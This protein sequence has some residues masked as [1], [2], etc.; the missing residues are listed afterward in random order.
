VKKVTSL[1][2]WWKRLIKPYKQ[3]IRAFLGWLSGLLLQIVPQGGYDEAITWTWKKWAFTLVVA[4][5]P[6]LMGFMKGGDTN[7]TDEELY[8]KVHKVKQ[9]RAAVGQEVTDPIGLPIAPKPPT[10]PAP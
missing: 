2:Q 8:D 5:I 6:G 9:M 10:T 7:P 4:A 3:Q 1:W